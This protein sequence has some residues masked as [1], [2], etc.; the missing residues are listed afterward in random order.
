MKKVQELGRGG[1][2]KN[3]FIFGKNGENLFIF[4][5]KKGPHIFLQEENLEILKVNG[6]KFG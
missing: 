1:G 4:S 3:L 6:G 5:K 2:V